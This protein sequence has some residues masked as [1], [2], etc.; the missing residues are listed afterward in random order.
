VPWGL[1]QGGRAER[2]LHGAPNVTT[3]SGD[4][5][6]AALALPDGLA[7]AAFEVEAEQ[8]ERDSEAIRAA[9]ER[10][11]PEV[12]CASASSIAWA[13]RRA[14]IEAYVGGPDHLVLVRGHEAVAIL[15][16]QDTVHP[17]VLSAVLHVLG[18]TPG[19]L[20]AYLATP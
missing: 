5:I 11:W 15:P 19:Q 12:P 13:L 16:L 14:G 3:E 6:L 8:R 1:P 10:W 20:A 7:R 4:R 17:A 18:V 2:K 9:R